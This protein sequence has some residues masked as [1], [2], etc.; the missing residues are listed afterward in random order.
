MEILGII[1]VI[2]VSVIA[3]F[4]VVYILLIFFALKIISVLP[5]PRSVDQYKFKNGQCELETQL[6]NRG[7][8]D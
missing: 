2:V 5:E 1:T 8:E 3:F 7:Q 6:M 4:V